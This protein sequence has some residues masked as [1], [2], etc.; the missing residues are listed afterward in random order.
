MGGFEGEKM[1]DVRKKSN[2]VEG[3]VIEVTKGLI[4]VKGT[5]RRR[6]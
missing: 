5:E 3:N 1:E 2:T 6:I 4:S